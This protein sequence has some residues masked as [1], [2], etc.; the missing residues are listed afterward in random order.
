[1]GIWQQF[2]STKLTFLEHLLIGADSA[3]FP[4]QLLN[5]EGKNR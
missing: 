4:N 2:G 3:A 1:V 5:D